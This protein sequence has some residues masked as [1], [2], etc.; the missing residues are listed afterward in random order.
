M[1]AGKSPCQ[2]GFPAEYYLDIDIVAPI[3][4]EVYTEALAEEQLPPTF[5]EAVITVLLKKDKNPYGPSSFRP[6]SLVNVDC[7]V[8]TK[9]LA[10]R[11]EKGLPQI[12]NDDQV[13]FIKGR[14]S[15]DNLR[16]LLHLMWFSSKEEVSLAAFSLHAM[17]AFDMVE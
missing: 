7:K 2:D 8:M 3:L 4:T 10:M 13:G 1:K 6:I 5:N 12:N 15:A 9:V 11:L 17:K 16:H 14:S